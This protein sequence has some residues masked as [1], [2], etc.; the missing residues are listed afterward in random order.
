M[1]VKSTA[2]LASA[3]IANEIPTGVIDNS[4]KDFQLINSPMDGTVIVRLSGI[5]Q[6]PGVSKDY[7]ISGSLI[8]FIKAPR[9][10]QEVAV[11]YFAI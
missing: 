4:N 7:T 9:N 5:V 2:T 10:N 6:V 3:Y 1:S 11:S 8:S